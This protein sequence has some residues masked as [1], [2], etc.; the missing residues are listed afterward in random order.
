MR[1]L[2]VGGTTRPLQWRLEQLDRLDA[3]L[4]AHSD[5][6]LEA[7]AKDLGKPDVEAYFEVVAVRQEISLCRRQL[8]RWIEAKV[9]GAPV[10]TTTAEKTPSKGF[11]EKS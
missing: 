4:S 6:V 3:A 7:L 1:Q 2:V 10:P 5:A 8:R 9:S 11:Q